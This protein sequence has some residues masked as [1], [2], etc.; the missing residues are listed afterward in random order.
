MMADICKE[1]QELDRRDLHLAGE[2]RRF[3]PPPSEDHLLS[4]R[5]QYQRD[6]V[7]KLLR[8]RQ[9]RDRI[10]QEKEEMYELMKKVEKVPAVRP[11]GSFAA[12]GDGS[13]SFGT[14]RS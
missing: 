13:R 12:R 6:E 1:R 4:P 9:Q 2:H 5:R 3:P 7:K 14:W 11:L 8:R 10:L